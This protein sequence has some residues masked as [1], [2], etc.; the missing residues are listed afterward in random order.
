MEWVF[1]PKLCELV[2]TA[3]TKLQY[4]TR[5]PFIPAARR[6]FEPSKMQ[7]YKYGTILHLGFRLQF[8]PPQEKEGG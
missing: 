2:K 4:I 6:L 7:I 5:I 1:S 8:G 3:L